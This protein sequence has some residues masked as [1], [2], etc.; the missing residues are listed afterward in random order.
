MCVLQGV[1]ATTGGQTSKQQ[2]QLPSGVNLYPA[3]RVLC[4]VVQ[5]QLQA[6]IPC[7][8]QALT[9]MLVAADR[10]QVRRRSRL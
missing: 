2:D 1:I 4:N 8:L 3:I 10:V 7:S 5:Q 6:K 9:N